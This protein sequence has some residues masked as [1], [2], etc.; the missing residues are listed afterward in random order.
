MIHL[1][2]LDLAAG[3]Q[4]GYSLLCVIL[5]SSICACL[6]QTLA[7]KLGSVTGLGS[8]LRR[9]TIILFLI[10]NFAIMT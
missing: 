6:L 4:F 1:S 3:S 7:V 2:I 9:S 5:L 10:F 8:F